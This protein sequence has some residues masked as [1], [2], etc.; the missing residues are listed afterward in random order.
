[1]CRKV[2]HAALLFGAVS[3]V[4]VPVRIAAQSEEAQRVQESATV[5]GEIMS[6]PDKAI[7][8]SVLNKAEGIAI[9]PGT[10]KGAFLI[11]AQHGRGII[12]ART[13]NSRAWSAP[14]FMTLTGGSI[15]A[16]IGAQAVDVVLVIMSRRGLT[17]LVSNE[18]K[19]GADAG[20]A[21]GQEVV[22]HRHLRKQ[23]AVLEGAGKPEPRD[24]VRLAARD[25]LAQ[26]A[27]RPFAVVDAAHAVEH[28]GLAG[29]VRPDQR[30]ELARLGRERDLVE[31]H[32]PAEPQGEALDRELSHTTSGSGD[33]A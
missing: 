23:F 32:Q 33:I 27:D 12:S 1:M 18:F 2:L 25:I 9:F 14:G 3:L 7:P 19:I 16:Q 13:E 30:Q 4:A 10:L 11:G 8:N 22:E 15:G 29:A 17:N 6:A 20:V 21:A 5:F 28:A 31:H 24:L 26:K